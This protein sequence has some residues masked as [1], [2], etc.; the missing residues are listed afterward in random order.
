[1]HCIFFSP[2]AADRNDTARLNHVWSALR[3]LQSSNLRKVAATSFRYK[4]EL[5]LDLG[6]EIWFHGGTIAHICDL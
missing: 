4:S 6:F 1:M 5:A 2:R 3:E